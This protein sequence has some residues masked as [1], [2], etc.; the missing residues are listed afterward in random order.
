MIPKQGKYRSK[1]VVMQGEV[2]DS[3]KEY[4]RYRDLILY[5]KG[6][7]ISAL[8]RQVAFELIPKQKG[9]TRNER[10][11]NY[12]ADFVYEEGGET[13]VEDVK[14]IRTKD[15]IIK[16][17]LMLLVHGIEIKEV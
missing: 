5:E 16:R 1:K 10:A 11:V 3:Q 14:G 7:L 4:S 12:I 13:V 2:F 9:N 8:Q 15:Y 6:G 17:K